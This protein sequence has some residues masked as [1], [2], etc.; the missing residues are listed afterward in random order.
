MNRHA[1][2]MAV[3]HSRLEAPVVERLNG[4]LIKARIDG[5]LD[6]NV[7]SF[8]AF[9]HHRGKQ[10]DALNSAAASLIGV[11]G[12]R[13]GDHLR[14]GGMPVRHKRNIEIAALIRDVVIGWNLKQSERLFTRAK[15]EQLGCRFSPAR[16][17]ELLAHDDEKLGCAPGFFDE[18]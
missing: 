16:I 4:L 6:S 10:H 9:I 15:L 17:V 5:M 8:A 3:L 13:L 1:H 2:G 18:D 7:L 12:L 11:F 14:G